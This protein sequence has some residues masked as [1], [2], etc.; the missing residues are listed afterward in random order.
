MTRVLVGV[1]WRFFLTAFEVNSLRFRVLRVILAISKGDV[2]VE[3]SSL[4]LSVWRRFCSS[5]RRRRGWCSRLVATKGKMEKKFLQGTLLMNRNPENGRNGHRSMND[6][7]RDYRVLDHK[8]MMSK[9]IA[10]S[11]IRNFIQ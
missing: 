4:W 1:Y 10:C 9:K 11:E 8:E 7:L 2:S 5:G 6:R 3:V